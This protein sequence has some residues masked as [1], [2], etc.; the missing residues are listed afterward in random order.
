M[1]ML[2]KARKRYSKI[3][4][5]STLQSRMYL[6]L[7]GLHYELCDFETHSEIW[8]FMSKICKT[9]KLH[10]ERI[11]FIQTSLEYFGNIFMK[12]KQIFMSNSCDIAKKISRPFAQ[13]YATYQNSRMITKLFKIE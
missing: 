13:N 9:Y 4:K 11:L 5:I 2:K 12:D 10:E 8:K 6:H 3:A 7:A 1:K